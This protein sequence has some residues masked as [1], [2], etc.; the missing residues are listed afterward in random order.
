[1]DASCFLLRAYLV[2]ESYITTTQLL[3]RHR[4]IIC[5][6]MCIYIATGRQIF[7]KRAELRSFSKL[8]DEEGATLT[9]P[10]TVDFRSIKVETEMKIETTWKHADVDQGSLEAPPSCGSCTSTKEFSEPIIALPQKPSRSLTRHEDGA[11][12]GYRATVFSTIPRTA[13][14]DTKRSQSLSTNLKASNK[15]RTAEGNAAAWSYFKVAFLM[16]AALFI[17]WVP[18]TVNRVQQ[19]F[20]KGHSIFGLNLASAL[21]LPLQGFWNAM[22]YVSTTW[23]ECKRAAGDMLVLLTNLKSRNRSLAFV[24]S[25]SRASDVGSA[26]L[27]APISLVAMK[28]RPESQRHLGSASSSAESVRQGPALGE[29]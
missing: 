24:R 6:T 21:V 28:G 5:A 11:H 4:V 27:V 8:P 26:N 25:S 1:M 10:F 29:A 22:I 7:K 3:T 20:D 19:F 14:T 9:N 18:S 15:R 12:N 17:V 2:I 13:D 23:P 16:F